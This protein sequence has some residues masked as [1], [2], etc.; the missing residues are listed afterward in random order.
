MKAFRLYPINLAPELRVPHKAISLDRVDKAVCDSVG[1]PYNSSISHFEWIAKIG[2]EIV[3]GSP[4]GSDNLR[5]L[6]ENKEKCADTIEASYEGTA[7]IRVLTYLEANY[8]SEVF[9]VEPLKP[10]HEKL[11]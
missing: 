5:Q 6:V 2:R 9:T 4:L 10:S 11:I 1:S 7:L 8:V 3:S